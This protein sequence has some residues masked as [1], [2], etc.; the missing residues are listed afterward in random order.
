MGLN[1]YGPKLTKLQ[2]EL[3]NEIN[4]VKLIKLIAAIT[5]FWCKK[6]TTSMYYC[7]E[8]YRSFSL[9]VWK[10]TWINLIAFFSIKLRFI[11][12]CWYNYSV[13]KLQYLPLSTR[14][15]DLFQVSDIMGEEYSKIKFSNW[16]NCFLCFLCFLCLLIF[17]L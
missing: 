3:P 9:N 10:N 5:S 8:W 4:V 12:R 2:R 7:N 17:E 11:L 13:P 1:Y 14:I 16:K 15:V 6:L